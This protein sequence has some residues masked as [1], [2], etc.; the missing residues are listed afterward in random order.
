[1]FWIINNSIE[2]R[3]A[4]ESPQ[5]DDLPPPPPPPG[6]PPAKA[7]LPPSHEAVEEKKEQPPSHVLGGTGSLAG[8]MPGDSSHMTTNKGQAAAQGP[9]EPQGPPPHQF[10]HEQWSQLS[11]IGYYKPISSRHVPCPVMNL[12][13][14]ISHMI[15]IIL[16][17]NYDE[18][19]II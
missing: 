14:S 9:T 19:M 2:A 8:H 10:W 4:E 17:W 13:Q 7:R 1:M 6:P 18:T 5:D 15:M 3:L 12:G 16:Y 11:Q